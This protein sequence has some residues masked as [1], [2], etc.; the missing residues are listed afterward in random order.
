MVQR[1]RKDVK[2]YNINRKIRNACMT[3]YKNIIFQ[4]K[5]ELRF[6]KMLESSGLKFSYE[7]EKI[8]LWE[9]FKPV[10]IKVY[11]PH[12]IRKGVYGKTLELNESKFI[13]ITYTPDFL[14]EKGKYRIYFDIKGMVND[15]YPLKKKMFLK[16]L[17][18]RTDY[19][20]MFFE[21][22]SVKQMEQALQIILEL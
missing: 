12:R 19:F 8:V 1:H 15:I 4:S 13:S 3:E 6:Y 2:S 16:I 22:H 21:P 20:Y 7:P 10:N 9:G 5:S 18:S 17:N 11:C 14:V